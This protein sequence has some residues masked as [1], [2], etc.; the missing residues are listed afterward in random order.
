VFTLSER[1]TGD[2]FGERKWFPVGIEFPDTL[3][4]RRIVSLFM[5]AT[6]IA[7]TPQRW[8]GTIALTITGIAVSRHAIT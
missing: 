2:L 1:L 7:R 4:Q 5:I 3:L 6:A 8:I